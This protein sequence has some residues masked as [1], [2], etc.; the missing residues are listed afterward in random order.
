MNRIIT[1]L[2]SVGLTLLLASCGPSADEV[3]SKLSDGAPLERADYE[4]MAGYVNDVCVDIVRLTDNDFD[5][6]SCHD[7]RVKA[8]SEVEQ[9]YPYFITFGRALYQA[10]KGSVADQVKTDEEV[11]RNLLMVAGLPERRKASMPES[12]RSPMITFICRNPN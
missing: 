4:T 11:A 9:T 6:P 2:L 7:D 5:N 10:P 12:W 1:I 8:L 3:Y